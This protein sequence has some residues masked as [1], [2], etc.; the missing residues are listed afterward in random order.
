MDKPV[1]CPIKGCNLEFSKGILGWHKHVERQDA[2]PYWHPELLGN[3]RKVAF[4]DEFPD[5]FV[6]ATGHQTP[7]ALRLSSKPPAKA[8]AAPVQ[9]RWPREPQMAAATPPSQ[10]PETPTGE[11]TVTDLIRKVLD[12]LVIIESKVQ[13]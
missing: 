12:I 3:L 2:H 7:A 9:D 13:R 1:K 10:A 11:P 6:N 8:Q 5:F 4:V